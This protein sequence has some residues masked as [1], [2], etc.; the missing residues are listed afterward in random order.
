MIIRYNDNDCEIN[1]CILRQVK[2]NFNVKI[3]LC[4]LVLLFLLCCALCMY[5]ASTKPPCGQKYLLN[6]KEQLSPST[7]NSLKDNIPS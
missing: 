4:P 6:H 7:N 3:F 2:E 1:I 5:Y